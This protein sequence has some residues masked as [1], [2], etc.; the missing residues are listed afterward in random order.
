MSMNG[1]DVS[2]HQTGINL[3]VVPCDFVIAKATQGTSYVN[4]DC[5]RAYQQAKKAGKCLGVYHY[6]S[7]GTAKAEADFFLKNVSGYVGEAVLVLDWEKE[8]NANYG[9]NDKAW[10]KEWLDYVYSKTGVRPLLY[11]SQSE[12]SKFTGI[13]D[14]GLWIAQYADNN[15]T[16]YQATPWNEGAYSCAIR[17]YSSHGRLNGYNGDLDLN[18]FY[19]DREAWNKYAGKGN[20]TKP[21]TGGSTSTGEGETYKHA[22][23]E[24]VSFTSCYKSSTECG[25][26]K[27]HIS[28]KDMLKTSGTITKRMK[29]NGTSVYLL[30]DGLCWVND[31]D[32][33]GGSSGSS[34]GSYTVQKNDTLSE[35]GAKLGVSWQ[36]I[37]SANGISSPYTIYVGQVL[38]IPGGGNSAQYYTI[39]SGDT[40]SA[41]SAKYG[42]TVSQLCQWNGIKDANK[43][44]AGQSIRVK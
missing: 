8:Q 35:I 44:Y 33:S 24:I 23:G 2:S 12:M 17:Q 30:D 7:G 6:A 34:G 28:A 13:G 26:Y 1:I 25:T 11:I 3:D 16:G 42:T 9:K 20:A 22:I 29:V 32:I 31:G 37:A 43:I 10:C 39:R 41:L 14:Y 15:P 21:S 18:K 27:N 19:G 36:S 38:K 5:D 40:L 4:P